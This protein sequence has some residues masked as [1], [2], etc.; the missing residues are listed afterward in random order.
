MSEQTNSALSTRQVICKICNRQFL[1]PKGLRLELCSDSCRQEIKKRRSREHSRRNNKRA[2]DRASKHYYDNREAKLLK[3]QESYD[4]SESFREQVKQRAKRTREARK[5]R[6]PEAYWRQWRS[7][8]LLRNY[9]ISLEEYE[10]LLLKQDGKCAICG[11]A[12]AVPGTKNC[13]AVDHDHKTGKVRGLLCMFCNRGL[14]AF[15][16]SPAILKNAMDYLL[17][18]EVN[19]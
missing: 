11:S 13:M 18:E 17:K 19:V 15:K 4:Q 14:G 2:R 12:E 5:E 16:D 7:K 8:Y 6:D 9:G 3:L 10:A 1:R